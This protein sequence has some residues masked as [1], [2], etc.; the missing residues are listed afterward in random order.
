ME[1][2]ARAVVIATAIAEAAAQKQDYNQDNNP[3]SA[4]AAATII[5]TATHCQTSLRFSKLFYEKQ[6]KVLLQ[7]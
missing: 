1:L 4:A 2:A 5:T 6:K 7:N 3:R